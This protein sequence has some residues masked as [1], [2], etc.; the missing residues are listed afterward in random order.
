MYLRRLTGENFSIKYYKLLNLVKIHIG[1]LKL[2][3]LIEN[4][5]NIL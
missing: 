5:E 2:Y 4:L 3:I 1:H